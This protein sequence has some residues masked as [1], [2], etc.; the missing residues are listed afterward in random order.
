MPPPSSGGVALIEMLNILEPLNLK[1]TKG[2][3]TVPA[4]HAQAEAMRR[5]YLDRARFLGDPDFSEIPVAR[6]TS[7]SHAT[8]VGASIDM[9]H[10]TSS[11]VLGKDLLGATPAP[12]PDETTHFSVLDRAGM[13][14]ATTYTLEGGFGSHLVVKG[15]G[16]ILN[17]EMGD[18]NKQPVT[19]TATGDMGT[20]PN[21]IAPGKRM[22][23]SMTPTIVTKSGKLV[24][25]T[26]SPGGRTII[27]TVLTVVLGV[28]E[29]GLTGRE[30]VD[31]PRIHHQWMP[32]RITY[33]GGQLKPP[34]LS[35]LRSLGHELAAASRQGDANTIWVSGDGTAYGV[36]DKRTPDGKA[37]VPA[38]L[39]A[40][41]AGR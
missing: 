13:A 19:T 25:I 2:L 24:L 37:S 14:V 1:L 33:E 9:L 11:A 40:R 41:P 27:N 34:V 17:N 32:D 12:E 15:A 31:L 35:G 8:Q 30:A 22:L 38:R 26:G 36:H 3:L 18:F 39:T 29:Y 7:K 4:L 20:P 16:F 6:L 28:T 5:A 21:L 10:G 23:S